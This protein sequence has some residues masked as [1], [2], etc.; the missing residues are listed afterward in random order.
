MLSLLEERTNVSFS[1]RHPYCKKVIKIPFAPCHPGGI[2]IEEEEGVQHDSSVTLF[3][4]SAVTEA[5]SPR[6]LK[7]D[8][9]ISPGVQGLLLC[10]HH[11]S[12][13]CALSFE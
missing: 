3:C 4:I 5:S 12:L 13:L 9:V 11:I 6:F 7:D 2:F 10:L 8:T 1:R